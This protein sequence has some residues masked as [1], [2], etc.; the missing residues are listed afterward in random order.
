MKSNT[1]DIAVIPADVIGK[2]VV[3]EPLRVL[4]VAAE[5]FDIG[6]KFTDH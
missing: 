5:R 3:P 1:F 4:E 6:L 2:E